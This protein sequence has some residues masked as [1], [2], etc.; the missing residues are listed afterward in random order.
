MPMY[1][2]KEMNVLVMEDLNYRNFTAQ[3]RTQYPVLIDRALLSSDIN[4]RVHSIYPEY[5]QRCEDHL[6]FDWHRFYL[7]LDDKERVDVFNNIMKIAYG[8]E[9]QYL[10]M[11]KK[12]LEGKVI[13]TFV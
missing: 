10:I 8:N 1:E 3:R 4:D 2:Y 13:D 7:V 6:C 11:N 9:V 12:K 5:F